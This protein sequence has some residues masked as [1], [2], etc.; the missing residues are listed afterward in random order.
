MNSSLTGSVIVANILNGSVRTNNS[1]ETS[2]STVDYDLYISALQY[3][4]FGSVAVAT[5]LAIIFVLLR[6]TA[7]F[8]K[9][10]LIAGL[11]FGDLIDG[12]ALTVIGALRVAH[13]FDGTNSLSVHPSYC[14]K[15]LITPM[16]LMGNQIPGVMFFLIGLERFLA[17]YYYDWYFYKWSNKFAWMLTACVYL[18]CIA[19]VAASFFVAF[20]FDVSYKISIACGTVSVIGSTYSAYNYGLAIIGGSVAAV[21]TVIAMILFA[22]RRNRAGYASTNDKAHIKKQWQMTKTTMCLTVVDFAF[23]VVPSIIITLSSGF[24]VD[25]HVN[26]TQLKVW[27][28]QLVCFRSILNLLIYLAVNTEFRSAALQSISY[29]IKGIGNTNLFINSVNPLWK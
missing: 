13:Y 2:T 19:S 25:F 5:N 8:K 4:T 28:L 26:I 16:F 1:V 27:A 12:F 9:S 22:K 20:S 24:N 21:A 15:I 6:N 18:F 17:V 7:Y 11:A 23:L 14:M 29:K 3:A 10:A